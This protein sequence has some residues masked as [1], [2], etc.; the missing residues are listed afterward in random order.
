MIT[1]KSLSIVAVSLSV[2]IISNC[3]SDKRT[4]AAPVTTTPAT[5]I[6][7]EVSDWSVYMEA[8]AYH[9]ARAKK[10]LENGD[11]L[12]AAAELKRGNTFLVF[13]S[14]RLS[15][16]SRE[17]EALSTALLNGKSGSVARLDTVTLAA[18]NV[19][20]NNF[21]VVPINVEALSVFE[22]A[23]KYHYDEAKTKLFKQEFADAAYEIRSAGSFLKIVKIIWPDTLKNELYTAG[24]EL[25]K[26]APEVE[27]GTVKDTV[28]LNLINQKIIPIVSR[29][30]K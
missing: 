5:V 22:D 21:A 16:A 1:I 27:S 12:R 9:F 20:K 8:P 14:K 30:K 17:I 19:I 10:Y 13:Q 24:T 7:T 26:L 23:Y 28:A 3:S 15:E 11:S 29:S 18:L 4:S 25:Q 6:Q 2:F